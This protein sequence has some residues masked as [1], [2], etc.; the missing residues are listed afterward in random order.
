[1]GQSQCPI[2][3]TPL[4]VRDVTPCFICGG[5]PEMVERFSPD[6][7]FREWRMPGAQ[8]IVLCHG[9]ELEEFMVPGGWGYRLGLPAYALPVNALQSV[10]H[11]E[12]PSLGRDKFCPNCK[13]RLAFL[14]V[15]SESGGASA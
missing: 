7:D 6:A 2:C 1:M 3:F 14:E 13:L 5:Q 9:C 8:L 12:Q 15:V 11:L 4:E 10:R